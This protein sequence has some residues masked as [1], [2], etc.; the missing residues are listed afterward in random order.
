MNFIDNA[1]SNLAGWSDAGI[2]AAIAA[3]FIC[4]LFFN[5]THSRRKRKRRRRERTYHWGAID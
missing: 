3:V 4:A 2:A 5:N 1:L